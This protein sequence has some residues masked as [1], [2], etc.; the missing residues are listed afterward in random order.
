MFLSV[1]RSAGQN[2]KDQLLE[3]CFVLKLDSLRLL[4]SRTV[5]R[6]TE[7]LNRSFRFR[8]EALR[9]THRS[10]LFP[11]LDHIIRVDVCSKMSKW[12]RYKTFVGIQKRNG[13]RF[14]FGCTCS[15]G[16][17]ST[18]CGHGILLLRLFGQVIPD[19]N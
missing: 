18:P 9:D 3:C 10:R 17:R 1:S 6:N 7:Q 13:Y 19:L 12:R 4:L 16:N 5:L 14:S 2:D 11:Q 8:V 15:T